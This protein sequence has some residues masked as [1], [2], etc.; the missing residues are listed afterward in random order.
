MPFDHA[1]DIGPICSLNIFGQTLVIVHSQ[2]LALEIMEKRSAVF[3]SRH[4]L[5]FG[6]EL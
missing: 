2:E 5:V 6:F 3:S 1:D 4:H